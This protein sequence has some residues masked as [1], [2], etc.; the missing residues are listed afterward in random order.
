MRFSTELQ[1]LIHCLALSAGLE[2]IVPHPCD[3][4]DWD[5]W[6][7]IAREARLEPFL[8]ARRLRFAHVELPKD[9]EQELFAAHRREACDAVFRLVA[10]ERIQSVLKRITDVTVLKGAALVMTLY[11]CAAERSMLDADLLFPS[12]EARN[13]ALPFFF[14]QGFVEKAAPATQA[15]AIDLT[16][17]S[18][19]F[20]VDLHINLRTPLLPDWVMSELW[21]R[22]ERVPAASPSFW[23]LDPVARLIHHCLHS[24]QD[25][26]DSPL[27]RNLF[28]VAWMASD[29][30]AEQRSDF[31]DCAERWQVGSPVGCVLGLAA[32][33]FGSP[34]LVPRP[35]IGARE[36]WCRARLEWT[37]VDDNPRLFFARHVSDHHFRRMHAGAS[38]RDPRPLV[39]IV[40]GS[41]LTSFKQRALAAWARARSVYRP[42]SARAVEVG[43]GLVLYEHDSGDVHMLQRPAALAW[44][45]VDGTRSR[46]EVIARL[47]AAGMDRA[48]AERAFDALHASCVIQY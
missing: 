8:Y 30:D 7:D 16:C 25:P 1:S 26:T 43:D 45:E 4:V 10:L 15:H 5:R 12:R 18:Q 24:I 23:V 38:D 2:P 33:L 34:Q 47:K 46:A 28:E 35:R 11:D 19:E 9:I 17:A 29:L 13:A 41:L 6:M 31:R 42:V 22:R 39:H 40:A 20:A 32:Q 14:D 3:S 21:Q 36:L 48:T 27:F 44:R 37:N